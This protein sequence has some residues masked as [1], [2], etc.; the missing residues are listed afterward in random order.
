MT[1]PKSTTLNERTQSVLN[2][3]VSK[4]IEEG[5]PVGSRTLSRDT[6]L[7]LS[8]ATIRNVMSELVLFC[9]RSSHSTRTVT[10]AIFERQLARHLLNVEIEP[11]PSPNSD[12]DG[13]LEKVIA[14]I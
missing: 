10:L 13:L 12:A 8:P 9:T 7:S 14:R 2:W 11:I 3:L 6:D 5:T 1:S 4:Y